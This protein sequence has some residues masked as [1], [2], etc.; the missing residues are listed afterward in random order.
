MIKAMFLKKKSVSIKN[1]NTIITK[2]NII[3]KGQPL[4]FK[5]CNLLTIRLILGRYINGIL[6]NNEL[7]QFSINKEQHHFSKYPKH[8]NIT[9]NNKYSK[10]LALSELLKNLNIYK[11][12]V[13]FNK[14]YILIFIAF[15][16]FIIKYLLFV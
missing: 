16:Q 7:Y 12:Q 4:I 8:S 14:L 2:L 1:K 15:L 10:R 5:S 3:K 13:V 9:L 6:T 11:E